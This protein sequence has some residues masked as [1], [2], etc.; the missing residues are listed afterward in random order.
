[1][2]ITYSVGQM[3]RIFMGAGASNVTLSIFMFRKI[4][5]AYSWMALTYVTAMVSQ[6]R[7]GAWTLVVIPLMRSVRPSKHHAPNG[8]ILQFF[9]IKPLR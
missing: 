4:H 6:I 8:I 3:H 2:I 5:T 9:E 7:F 1:M